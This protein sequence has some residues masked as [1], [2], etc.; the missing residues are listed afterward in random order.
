M[1]ITPEILLGVLP[2]GSVKYGV[3]LPI[4]ELKRI[5]YAIK[6]VIKL[7]RDKFYRLKPLDIST[8][9]LDALYWKGDSYA[10]L[11]DVYKTAELNRH[12]VKKLFK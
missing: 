1:H 8:L 2:L 11:L 9:L 7:S 12:L 5:T 4:N 10:K 3:P 6:W